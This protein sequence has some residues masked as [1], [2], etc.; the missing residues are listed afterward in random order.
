MAQPSEDFSPAD[1]EWAV[2]CALDFYELSP[3]T[4]GYMERDYCYATAE[5][6][7]RKQLGSPWPSGQEF[8][9]ILQALDNVEIEHGAEFQ[10]AIR[11]MTWDNRICPHGIGDNEPLMLSERGRQF[12]TETLHV[13]GPIGAAEAQRA[14]AHRME[15]EKTRREFVR[16]RAVAVA[17]LLVSLGHLIYFVWIR[18]LLEK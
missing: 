5:I 10:E 4:H 7:L 3:D 18:P 11:R 9:S 16:T 13:L 17:A 6:Y 12:I 8:T 14:E 2:L 1:Y 15:M